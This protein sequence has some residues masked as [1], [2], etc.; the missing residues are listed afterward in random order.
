MGIFD[1]LKNS[2]S[3]HF[4]KKREE[5]EWLER[6]QKEAVQEERKVF[7]E[8]FKKNAFEV[9]KK[10]AFKDAAEKSGLAKLQAINRSR[11]LSEGN[12]PP[13][14]F[15]SRLSEFTKKNIANREENLSRTKLM[16]EEA[17]KIREEKMGEKSSHGPSSFG[18]PSW[19]M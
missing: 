5:K 7:E 10:R 18:S 11:R 8:Q 3:G 13:G 6:L 2:L 14:S 19:K 16:R 15:F 17:Q 4:D 9:A 1:S 12:I